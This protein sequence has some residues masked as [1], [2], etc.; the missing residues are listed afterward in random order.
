MNLPLF[1]KKRFHDNRKQTVDAFLEAVKD[2]VLANKDPILDDA[3]DEEDCVGKMNRVADE[4]GDEFVL[5][6]D[7]L[8]E[9]PEPEHSRIKRRLEPLFRDAFNKKKKMHER[10]KK[11]Q[12]KIAKLIEDT[13]AHL[14]K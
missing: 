8:R 4:Y 9:I 13:R 10:D 3:V 7:F 12:E 2:G 5:N 14:D 1:S 6:D 11:K